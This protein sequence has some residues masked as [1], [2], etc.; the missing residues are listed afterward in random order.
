[1][2]YSAAGQAFAEF[3][4]AHPDHPLASNAQYWLGESYYVQKDYDRAAKA[5]LDG[6]Q[7]FRDGQKAPDSLLKL[8]ASL[9]AM[10]E[11]EEACLA[12]RELA[13]RFP[14]AKSPIKRK[15]ATVRRR[16]GCS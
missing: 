12:L 14:D 3:L 2:D 9:N 16:A 4:T 7:R 11:K 8:G 6:Y 15:A 10:D 13:T 5:F 1:M